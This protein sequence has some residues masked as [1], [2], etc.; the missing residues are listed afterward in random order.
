MPAADMNPKAEC[1][2]TI[3]TSPTPDGAY[4]DGAMAIGYY[5]DN[6]DEVF[7]QLDDGT[8]FNIQCDDVNAFCRAVKRAKQFAQAQK[9]Q[10]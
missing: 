6:R 4:C 9:V 3:F 2:T 8:V 1:V 10:E 5:P 7:L